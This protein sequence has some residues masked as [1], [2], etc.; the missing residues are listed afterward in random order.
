MQGSSEKL[1][2]EELKRVRKEGALPLTYRSFP[3]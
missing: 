3:S 2:M 1:T